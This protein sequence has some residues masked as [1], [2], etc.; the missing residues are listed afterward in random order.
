M[1]SSAAKRRADDIGYWVLVA[2]MVIAIGYIVLPVF[3]AVSMSFDGR[4]YLGTFPPRELSLQWYYEFFGSSYFMRSLVTS[5]QIAALATIIAAVI[6]GLAALAL[7]RGDTPGRRLLTT[8]FLSPLMVPGVVVGFG[9]LLFVTQYLGITDG[10]WRILAG[11]VV[12]AT[13]YMIRATLGGLAGIQPALREAALVLGAN[14]RQ[15]FW[16]VTF[17]LAKT[18]LIAGCI[19]AFSV[20]LDDVA[21]ALFLYDPQAVTLPVALVTYMRASFDL[22]VAAATVF[23]ATTN[24]LL[25]VVLDRA[26]GLD[27]IVG[28]GVYKP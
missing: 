20:S 17:P 6:G 28:Q 26:I 18:G 5:L 21:V 9:I 8:F 25:I 16:D 3:V 12:I 24:L 7:H 2:I 15:A 10:F 14:E 13:P 22:S 27:R 19:F 23:L 1:I 4:T 11:H